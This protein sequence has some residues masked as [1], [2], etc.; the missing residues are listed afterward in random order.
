MAICP[1]CGKRVVQNKGNATILNGQVVHKNCN[2]NT[3]IKP[4]LSSD[5]KQDRQKLLDE[6]SKQLVMNPRGYVAET[7][8]NFTKVSVQIGELKKR[9]YSYKDQLYALNEIVKKQEGFWGYTAV[10][11]NIA[12]VIA[13]RDEQLRIREQV[14]KQ[15]EQK[16]AYSS[17]TD[18]H[19]LMDESEDW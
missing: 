19:L 16:D 15:T 6:I 11:N 8:L 3:N 12:G 7:G 17:M 1:L 9:G 13:K 4:K 5:E 18:L 10:V 14:K 2:K